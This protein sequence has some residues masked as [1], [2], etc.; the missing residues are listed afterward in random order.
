MHHELGEVKL[1]RKRLGL[2]Q[3]ELAM[4]AGVSQSLI[5][6]VEAGTIDPSY[7][8][9]KRIVESLHAFTNRQEATAAEVMRHQVISCKEEEL[10]AAA[11]KK[12][13]RHAISQLPVLKDENIVG[14]LSETSIIRRMEEISHERTRVGDVMEEAPPIIPKATPRRVIAELLQHYNLLLVKERGRL[15]GIITRA[16]LLRTV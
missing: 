3:K 11:I 4:A 13:E 14:L 9:G 10:L 2:T 7:S 15:R 1:L 12:M 8:A 6:K 5:A 16:D